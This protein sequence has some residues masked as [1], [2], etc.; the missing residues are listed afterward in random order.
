MQLMDGCAGLRACVHCSV[1]ELVL[2][3]G[4]RLICLNSAAEEKSGAAT[5]SGWQAS[6]TKQRVWSS[7]CDTDSANSLAHALAEGVKHHHGALHV[8]VNLSPFAHVIAQADE[9]NVFD[10]HANW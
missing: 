1:C 9:P 10:A 5:V 3:K 7:A 8:F 2:S 4:G 6:H